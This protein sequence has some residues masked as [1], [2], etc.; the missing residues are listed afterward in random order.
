[1]SSALDR[2]H[3][4]VV[5][6]IVNTLG[7]RSLRAL[8]DQAIGPVLDG[9]DALSRS[10]SPWWHGR[11]DCDRHPAARVGRFVVLAGGVCWSARSSRPVSSFLRRR[12]TDPVLETVVERTK[13]ASGRGRLAGAPGPEHTPRIVRN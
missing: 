11:D 4:V 3:P 6:R 1:V 8:Q 7:W 12:I 9:A 5:H 2:L 13:P 10:G